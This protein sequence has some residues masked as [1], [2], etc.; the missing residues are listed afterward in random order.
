MRRLIQKFLPIAFLRLIKRRILKS[1]Y[2]GREYRCPF[3]LRRFRK[4]MPSGLKEAVLS[5]KQ[6]IG[7]GR[8][9][10]SKC[11]HCYANERERLIY[12]YLKEKTGLLYKDIN[13]LDIGPSKQIMK[14][15]TSLRN[16]NYIGGDKYPEHIRQYND[17]PGIIELDVL[18]MPF[19][20]N[21]FDIVICSHV[22][23]EVED[24]VEGMREIRR[25]L[26]PDGIAIIQSPIAYGLDK[27]IEKFDATAE[28]RKKLFGNECYIRLYSR[29]D[30][31][32]RLEKAGFTVSTYNF[33]DDDEF[34]RDFVRAN[35]LHAT[36]DLYIVTKVK[37][38]QLSN[39]TA[40]S[41]SAETA[42]DTLANL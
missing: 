25:V 34:G 15:L 6:V 5:E 31:V 37:N 35:A 9:I 20:D 10:N 27:T 1:Y 38:A 24:D 26:K 11:P 3:C 14:A 40:A 29:D 7:A 41:V 36:E 23:D 4:F 12:L 39:E 32:Q 16:I 33:F 2:S 18:N 17:L 13:V 8:R 22:I 42:T 19:S 28:E 30:Y 21:S